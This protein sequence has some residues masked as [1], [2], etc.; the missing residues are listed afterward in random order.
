M[1]ASSG[2]VSPYDNNS[3]ILSDQLLCKFGEDSC[4]LS[5]RVSRLSEQYKLSDHSKDESESTSPKDKGELNSL[6]LEI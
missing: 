1:K 4:S 6:E 2:E 5:D 3:P